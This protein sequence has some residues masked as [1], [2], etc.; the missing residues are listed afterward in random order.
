[1]MQYTNEMTNKKPRYIKEELPN[2]QFQ[3]QKNKIIFYNMERDK[4]LSSVKLK[5]TVKFKTNSF[6][7]CLPNVFF[8][9]SS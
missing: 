9:F 4:S 1:M 8:T 6:V 5:S 3:N 7:P 2:S